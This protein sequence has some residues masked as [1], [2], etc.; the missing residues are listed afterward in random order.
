MT[1][2]L[3]SAPVVLEVRVLDHLVIGWP[4]VVSLAELGIV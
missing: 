3:R 1:Q 2:A 4:D